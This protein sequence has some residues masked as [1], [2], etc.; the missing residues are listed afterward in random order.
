MEDSRELR[1]VLEKSFE[2]EGPTLIAVPID[3]RENP[4]LTERLGD[5][6]CPI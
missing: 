2:T 1:G 5:I 6:A 3:Y 4:K